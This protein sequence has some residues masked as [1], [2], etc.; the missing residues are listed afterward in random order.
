MVPDGDEIEGK[1]TDESASREDGLLGCQNKY[2][3]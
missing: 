2:G 1:F 3:W